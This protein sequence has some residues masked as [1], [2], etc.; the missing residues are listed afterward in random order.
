MNWKQFIHKFRKPWNGTKLWLKCWKALFLTWKT[1]IWILDGKF[2]SL[3]QPM[4][5]CRIIFEMNA[6]F[7]QK[8][9]IFF[10]AIRFELKKEKILLLFFLFDSDFISWSSVLGSLSIW[11]CRIFNICCCF[12]EA[13][14]LE[15]IKTNIRYSKL[16]TS[17]SMSYKGY[18]NW[19]L[20]FFFFPAYV[21]T[22]PNFWLFYSFFSWNFLPLFYLDTSILFLFRFFYPFFVRTFLHLFYLNF[23]LPVQ[24]PWNVLWP[25]PS[26]HLADRQKGLRPFFAPTTIILQLRS[27]IVPVNAWKK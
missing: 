20:F 27:K 6:W 14:V 8:L 7:G 24:P 18:S 17:K 19:F 22:F 15:K 13:G 23:Y 1:Y 4:Q 21:F 16:D 10:P 5:S 9:A 3:I 26:W 12:L 11:T 2:I 25:P